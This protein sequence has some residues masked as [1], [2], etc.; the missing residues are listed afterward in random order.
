MYGGGTC[1][2]KFTVV[3]FMMARVQQQPKCHTVTN[4]KRKCVHTINTM[5]YGQS[6]KKISPAMFQNTEKPAEHLGK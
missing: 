2:P 4:G 6:F 3:L 1:F 5:G